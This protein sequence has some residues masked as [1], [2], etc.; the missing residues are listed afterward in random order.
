[1]SE[2]QF[3]CGSCREGTGRL[4]TNCRLDTC[5][6]NSISAEHAAWSACTYRWCRDP[7]CGNCYERSIAYNSFRGNGGYLRDSSN[8][9]KG[10][11]IPQFAESFSK[12][13][14][15][16]SS[17][18]HACAI[19]K[20]LTNVARSGHILR[21]KDFIQRVLGKVAL[22]QNDL[23]DRAAGCQCQVGD[24]GGFLVANIRIEGSH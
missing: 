4:H 13:Q 10:I 8:E 17:L 3:T 9:Q 23:I 1:M 5:W 14:V 6:Q 2:S 7:F 18:K 24:L 22:L 16:C 21:R 19:L 11:T 20:A 12:W 15:I